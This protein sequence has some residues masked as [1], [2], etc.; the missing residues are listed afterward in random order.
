MASYWSSLRFVF[1]CFAVAFGVTSQGVLAQPEIVPAE[2]EVY[3]FLHHQRVRGLLPEYRHE[4]RPLGRAHVGRLL[5]SLDARTSGG[6]SLDP[7]SARWLALFTREI[8][9]PDEAIEAILG[10]QGHL[11]LPLGSDTE[12]FLL[13][14]RDADWRVALDAIGRLQFRLADAGERYDG[15]ALVPEG[16]LQGNYRG[17]IGFYSGTFDGQQ[18]GGDT[19]VLQADPTLAPLYYIGRADIPPGSFDRSTA[20]LRIAN[21]TFS[22]EIAHARLLLGA[23]FDDGLILTESADYFSF[24]RLGLDTRVVQ[25][26]FVHG[27]LGDRSFSAPGDEESAILLGPERYVALH[28]LTVN[29]WRRLGLAFT[30]MVIYGQRGPEL[31]YLNPLLPIKPT[32]HALWD[33]DNSLFALEA[34]FRPVDGVEVYGTFLA[35]DLDFG[36]LGQNSFNNKWAVQTGVGAAL[37]AGLGWVE[38]TRIEPFVYTHRFL[39]DGSFYNSYQ[40]NGFGLG[41]PLGP[42]ADQVEAGL[43]FWLPARVRGTAKARWVR[44]GENYLD[45]EGQF[46]NVGGD[47]GDGRQPPFNDFSK[48]FLAGERFS[49]PGATLGLTWEPIRDYAF[50]VFADYQRWDEAP[51]QLFVRTELVV[52]L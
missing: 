16:I 52:D 2:H 20:S 32:E 1:L 12:K 11:R 15:V 35:D 31:A 36:R 34:V 26:Q 30:E 7:A 19:R 29:P 51:N 13:Y 37:G 38:Y 41:H 17:F 45:A 6:A 21:Q 49:G 14:Y 27:A 42:N 33:R 22:A 39:L 28:R 5:D 23:S 9:E 48:V 43:R 24:L 44:R 4:A 46:V 3:A 10:P 8:H 18:F 47:I 50:N 40:H 25:Y